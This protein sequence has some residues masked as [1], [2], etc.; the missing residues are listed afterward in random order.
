MSGSGLED[1]FTPAALAKASF[2]SRKRRR[3]EH[4]ER[5]KLIKEFYNAFCEKA[6]VAIKSGLDNCRVPFSPV[7]QENVD[8]ILNYMRNKGFTIFH[9][10]SICTMQEEFSVYWTPINE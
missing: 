9:E 3:E 6:K 2:A 1:A 4:E 10:K 8:A 5:D 7:S